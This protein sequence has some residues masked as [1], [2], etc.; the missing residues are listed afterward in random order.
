MGKRPVCWINERRHFLAAED[1]LVSHEDIKHVMSSV[2]R[3]GRDHRAS[4]DGKLHRISGMAARDGDCFYAMT[5]HAPHAD[6]AQRPRGSSLR[7]PSAD[8]KCLQ[9]LISN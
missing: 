7:D 2:G 8:E 9:P 3:F 1:E 6:G 4:I 5:L